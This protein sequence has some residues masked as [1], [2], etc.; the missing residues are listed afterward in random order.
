LYF[1]GDFLAINFCSK[2]YRTFRMEKSPKISESFRCDVCDYKCCK[3]S[4]WNKHISTIKH[5]K[6]TNLATFSNEQLIC[7][8]CDYKC[9]KQSDLDKHL[10]TRKHTKISEKNEKL[11]ENLQTTYACKNCNKELYNSYN[12]Y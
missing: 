11:A 4:E 6:R 1:L 3:L 5:A 8:Q 9:Y 2:I 12:N 10:L 7:K